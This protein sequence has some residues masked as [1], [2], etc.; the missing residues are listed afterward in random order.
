LIHAEAAFKLGNTSNALMQINTI[1]NRAGL[2]SLT[3][4]TIDELY[5][6]RRWEMAM[7]HERWF[8]IIRTG[9]ARTAMLAVGKN[10]IVG[11]HELFPIPSDQIIAS[12]GRLIQNP[13]Y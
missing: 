7:E 4:L 12:G 10:F 2:A 5:N 6:E 1:R 11:T 9:K 8:D 13:G 3:S